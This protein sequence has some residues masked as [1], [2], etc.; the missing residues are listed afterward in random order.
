MRRQQMVKKNATTKSSTPTLRHKTEQA[1]DR[2]VTRVTKLALL[3]K[4][5]TTAEKIGDLAIR[6]HGRI[7][8]TVPLAVTILNGRETR[9]L[10]EWFMQANGE[11]EIA[12]VLG[13]VIAAS[14][15]VGRA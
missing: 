13:S 4:I 6:S 14:R 9:K 2:A 11:E 15:M 7:V 3:R 12:D 10:V 8:D 5:V 1:L